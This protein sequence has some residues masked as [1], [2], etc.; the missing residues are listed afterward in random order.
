MRFFSMMIVILT[1]SG[2]AT[3]TRYTDAS[4][5][6]Y[7]KDTEYAVETKEDGFL[8]SVLYD[9]YQFIPESSALAVACKSALTTIAYEYAD[10]VGK[11]IQPVNEQR[12]KLSMGRN[13]LNGITSCSASTLVFWEK[14]LLTAPK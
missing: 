1:L 5:Q 12:I 7:D 11:K 3:A 4:M 2:C 8:L 6:S 14:Q 13:G 9:R 10:K